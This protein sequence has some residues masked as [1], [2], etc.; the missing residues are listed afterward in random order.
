MG[1]CERIDKEHVVEIMA[2]THGIRARGT[3]NLVN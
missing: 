2:E 3:L 1:K